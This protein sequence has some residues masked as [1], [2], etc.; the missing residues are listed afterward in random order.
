MALTGRV[1]IDL[2]DPFRVVAGVKV[3][4]LHDE[5]CVF[6]SVEAV[7]LPDVL[8]VVAG[9]KVCCVL[10]QVSRWWTYLTYFVLFQVPRFVVYCCR[11][12]DGGPT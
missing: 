5:L 4:L 9:A 7:D 8:C 12:Q 1:V 2:P 11:C 10:L 6:E 3:V